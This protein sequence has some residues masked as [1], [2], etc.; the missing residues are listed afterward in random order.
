M[1]REM[2]NHCVIAKNDILAVCISYTSLN[3]REAK[4][5]TTEIHT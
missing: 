2:T 3:V 4:R 5:K 1:G